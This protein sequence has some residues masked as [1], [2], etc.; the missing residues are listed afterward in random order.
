MDGFQMWPS[1]S[2]SAVRRDAAS[3]AAEWDAQPAAGG[4]AK[5]NPSFLAQLAAGYA[6]G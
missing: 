6:F 5:R 4:L 1:K 3:F 2:T